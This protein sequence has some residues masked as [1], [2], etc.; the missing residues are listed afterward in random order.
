MYKLPI[1]F[2]LGLLSI[3]NSSCKSRKQKSSHS[4]YFLSFEKTPCFGKCPIYNMTANH[5]GDLVL[6]AKRFMELEGLYKATL[7]ET[8]LEELNAVINNL[9]WQ[10]LEEEYLIGYS[11]LPSTEVKFSTTPGDTIYVR[12]ESDRAPESLL[13]LGKKMEQIQKNTSWKALDID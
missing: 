2:L 13:K 5:K 12:W 11:D 4:E 10:N 3:Y 1:L 6:D 7:N 9:D 8:G